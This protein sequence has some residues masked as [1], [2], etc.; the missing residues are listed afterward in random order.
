MQFPGHQH[1][2]ISNGA[3]EGWQIKAL[4]DVLTLKRGYDLPESKRSAGEIP[5]VSSS[6]YT[7]YH[8][9]MRVRAPGVGTGRYG[10]LGEV[11]FVQRDFWPLNTALY[12]SDF[13]GLAPEFAAHLLRN[14]LARL[15]SDKAAVP[16]LN[17]N[18]IH[19]M[20]VLVPP[21]SLRNQF[22]AFASLSYRQALTLE[23]SCANLKAARDFLLPRLM[24]GE[25]EV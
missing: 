6:G 16:G 18:V 9:E 3:P 24:S 5:V 20:A 12:V 11:F 19:K 15:Q 21:E 17:R 4:G 25:V 14:L 8:N 10:T 1:S 22:S 2:L 7:G 13:K 23:N